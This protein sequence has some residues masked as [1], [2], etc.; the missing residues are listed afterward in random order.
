MQTLLRVSVHTPCAVACIN[1][2]AHVKDRWIMDK[3]KTLHMHSRLGSAILSQLGIPGKGN[4]NFPWEKFHWDNTVVKSNNKCESVCSLPQWLLA[5]KTKSFADPSVCLRKAYVYLL[6][7][8]SEQ[9]NDCMQCKINFLLGPQNLL[10]QLPRDGNWHG[11][12]MSRA[13]TASPN[14]SFRAPWRVGRDL[15]RKC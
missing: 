12:G 13:T 5:E 15:Q 8:Y 10:W 11:S 7:S 1:I 2:C 9:T 6:V 4:P 14:P 3:L